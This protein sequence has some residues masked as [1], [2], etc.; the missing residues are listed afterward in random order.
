MTTATTNTVLD[1]STDAGFRTLVAEIITALFTTVGA[2]QTADTGQ[3]NTSTV[4]RA[5]VANTAAGY[6]IGRFNDTLQST[7]PIF[8]KLEF[9]SGAA[10]ATAPAMWMTVGTGSNGSG[11]IT[12]PSTRSQICGGAIVS[13]TTNY[14]SRWCY[15]TTDGILW[16]SW[17]QAAVAGSSITAAGGFI[18]SR[19]TDSSGAPNSTAYWFMSTGVTGAPQASGG[20]VIIWLYGSSTFQSLV[21]FGLWAGFPFNQSSTLE[22]G[23]IF[24]FPVWQVTPAISV[25]ANVGI[26]I[27]GEIPLGSTIVI[28]LVATTTHTFIAIGDLYGNA[29]PSGLSAGTIL[30]PWE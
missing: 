21:S 13:N 16:M 2:T 8:F 1:Q 25:L 4:T 19:S 30:L 10:G 22:A 29:G 23:T 11:T 3:I 17:K 26:G 15:N 20:G 5:A 27:N 24:I 12:N 18:I 28:A 9:G 6:V 14:V 7:S